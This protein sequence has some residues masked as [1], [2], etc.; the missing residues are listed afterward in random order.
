M[1]DRSD[2]G[3]R[4]DPGRPTGPDRVSGD[5]RSGGMVFLA[6]LSPQDPDSTPTPVTVPVTVRSGSPK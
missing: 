4:R 1:T 5:S 2:A 6:V 3:Q